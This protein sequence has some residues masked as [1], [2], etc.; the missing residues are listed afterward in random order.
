MSY[1]DTVVGPPQPTLP[2]NV[3]TEAYLVFYEQR[4]R[5]AERRGTA[6][7]ERSGGAHHGTRAEV[8]VVDPDRSD[9][10]ELMGQADMTMEGEAPGPPADSAPATTTRRAGTTGWTPA[11]G[12][13]G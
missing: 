8:I 10:D 9:V 2:P 12:S 11:E 13:E 7:D 4:P 6:A 3:D 1:D 5:E